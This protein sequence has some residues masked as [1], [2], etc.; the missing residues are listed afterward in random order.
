MSTTLEINQGI[1]GRECILTKK[2]D[3]F[4]LTACEKNLLFPMSLEQLYTYLL[5]K[6]MHIDLEL[7]KK[8]FSD[9]DGKEVK[10]L[11]FNEGVD[12]NPIIEI[13]VTQDQMKAYLLLIPFINGTKLINQHIEALLREQKIIYGIKK[14]TISELISKQNEYNEQLIA[15]GTP[16][17][18]GENASLQFYFST[19]GIDIKPQELSD[20]SVDFY[21]LNLIQT[22][23]AGKMLVEKKLPKSGTNG[24]TV[25]G[26]E[27]KASPGKDIRLPNGQNT[28]NVDNTK[29]IATKTGHVVYANK[30]VNVLSSYE[31]RG[32]VDFNTGN[33]KF[34]GNVVVFGDV[35]NN[36]EVEASGDVEIHGNLEGTV[37][38]EGNLMVKKGIVRGKAYVKG[39]IYARYIENGV[40]ESNA[41]IIVTDAIMHSVNKAVQKVIVGGKKGL[42][43]GGT[44]CAGEE[45][46]ARNIGSNMGTGTILEVGIRPE[47]RQEYKEIHQ[48]LAAV[49]SDYAKT[50]QILKT[51]QE[52]KQKM[53]ELSE[54]K[55]EILMK[56]TRL[57]YHLS[58]EIEELN[59][60]KNEL[61]IVFLNMEKAKVIVEEQLYTG[62]TIYMGKATFTVFDEMR[63]VVFTLEGY[64]IKYLP[65]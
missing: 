61:E 3:G 15:E 14:E 43:V 25:F 42:L 21:N 41:S 51:L 28:Q 47:A 49:T 11:D 52:M 31:V 38:T 27:K 37:K 23:E 65:L 59:E 58:Q 53:G 39:S 20:G 16:C 17:V 60:R 54:D 10:I 40:A 32:D 29:L 50:N 62:V 55:K 22:V 48:K 33:I 18:P 30:K 64:D 13:K 63:R 5:R 45:I 36:F 8:I 2:T 35:K 12:D 34:P 44:C 56:Y 7:I 19:Q 9:A 57:Q 4:Y 46:R 1:L 24:T 6:K 26:E